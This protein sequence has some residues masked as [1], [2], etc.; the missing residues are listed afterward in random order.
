MFRIKGIYPGGGFLTVFC[1]CTRA[2]LFDLA[3]KVLASDQVGDVVI[4]LT[5]LLVLLGNV[6]VALS[7]LAEGSKGVGSEL[8]QDTRDEL[9]QLLVLAGTVDGEGVGGD[10]GVNC[11][12]S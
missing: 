8:V 3:L 10:S 1:W 7:E 2:N 6:L 4:V 5:T 12:T 9:S 11:E